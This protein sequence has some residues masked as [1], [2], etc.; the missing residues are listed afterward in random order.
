MLVEYGII[1]DEWPFRVICAGSEQ[2]VNSIDE[3]NDEQ[4]ESVVET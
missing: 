2:P 1:S 3:V 4:S